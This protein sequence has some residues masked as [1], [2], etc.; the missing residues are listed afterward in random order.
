M[1]VMVLL[2]ALLFHSSSAWSASPRFLDLDDGTI[3]DTVSSLK[4]LKNSNCFG[5]KAWNAA[6]SSAGNLASGQ[7]GLND[8]SDAGDWHLPTVE[9][10]R[11]FTDAGYRYDTLNSAGFDNVQSNG[12]AFYW[13]GTTYTGGYPYAAWLVSMSFGDV[14]WDNMSSAYYVWPVRSGQDWSL[15]SL[16]FFASFRFASQNV[17]TT[18]GRQISIINSG[19]Y[20]QQ[21]TSIALVGTNAAEFTIIP[22]GTSPCPGLSP[23]LNAGES[24]SM[25]VA[26]G[27][28]SKGTKSANVSIS[29]NAQTLN[30][31]LTATGIS[32]ITGTAT[33]L[34]TGNPLAA[35]TITITGGSTT[36]SD[37]SGNFI[38][39]PS[40][41]D[42]I[43]TVTIT[44]SG[45]GSATINNV[46]ISDSAGANLTVGMAPAGT[47]V[48]TTP[49]PTLP[50]ATVGAAYSTRFRIS[51]GM[52]P[53]TFSIPAAMGSLPPG[54]M[55][56]PALGT[57]TGTPISAGSYT[58]SIN[59][60][61]SQGVQAEYYDYVVNVAAPLDIA[62]D[63]TLPRGTSNAPYST[64]INVTGGTPPYQFGVGTG[65][66]NGVTINPTSGLISG[67]PAGYSECNHYQYK[68]CTGYANGGGYYGCGNWH[69]N[70]YPYSCTGVLV[71][72]CVS[73]SSID[74]AGN[75][76][77]TATVTD[78]L[79]RTTSKNCSINVDNP[80]SL[81]TARLNDGIVGAAFTQTPEA[82]GGLAPYSWAVYSGA[83]PAG[84]TLDPATGTISGTPSAAGS[85]M[86]VISL[87][88][89]YNRVAFKEF[90]LNSL[91]PLQIVTTSM[92]NG[93]VGAPYS[94]QVRLD[95][96]NPPF[97][98][99]YS[100]SL[101]L[102]LNLAPATGIVSGTSTGGG[103]TN[104]SITVT[105]STFPSAQ[106]K[107]QN[108]S[109]RVWTQL[110][111]DSSAVLGNA[112]KNRGI[113]AVQL[114]ARGGVV[115]SGYSWSISGGAFPAGIAMTPAGIISGTP[116]AAGDYIATVRVTDQAASP[117]SAEKQFFIHVSDTL[118]VVTGA[119]PDG[120]VGT[121][122]TH[123][124]AA[125]GGLPSYSWA[126]KTGTLPAGL[127]LNPGGSI[128]GTPTSKITSSVTFEVTD[129]DAPAQKAQRSYTFDISDTLSIYDRSL[130]DGR[131]NHAY[132]ANI[133]PQL[134]SAP[135]SWALK[136]GTLPPG[137]SLSHNAGVATISGSATAA[138]SYSFELELSDN[139]TPVQRVVRSYSIRIVPELALSATPL[140]AAV[141]GVPYA[142]SIAAT[143]G[144]PPYSFGI[145]SGAL[146][147]GLTLNSSSG[148]ISGTI[149]L[150]AGE[151]SS[152][153]V[154]VTDDGNPQASVQQGFSIFAVD[155]LVIGT[156][157][158]QDALQKSSYG[159]V[160]LAGSGGISPYS[161][162]LADGTTLPQGITLSGSGSLAGN[163]VVCGSFPL[164][165]QAADQVGTAQRGYTLTILC[166][167]DYELAG[168][169]G[170]N[171]AGAMVV[172]SGAQSKSATADAGGAYLFRHLVN[173]SYSVTPVL[174]QRWFAEGS[175]AVTV[176]NLDVGGINFSS[177]IDSTAPAVTGFS[178]PAAVSSSTVPVTSLTAADN[179]GGSG[180]AGYLI[181]ETAGTPP[182]AAAG[183]SAAKPASY[184]FASVTSGARVLYAWTKDV[185][186]NISAALTATVIIDITAPTV[187]GF[188][189]P[190][191]SRS[192]TVPVST[193]SAS[194]AAGGSGLSGYLIRAVAGEPLA[195][196]SGWSAA[197]PE[198]FTFAA[199]SSGART[200]YAWAR[201]GAGNV[202]T[203]LSAP[204]LINPSAPSVTA[205]SLPAAV[206]TLQVP[207][208]ILTASADSDSI[209]GYLLTET[210]TLPQGSAAGWSAAKPAS[211]TMSASADGSRTIYAW[212]KDG[213]GN[214]SNWRSKTV[215]LDRA[216]P[217]VTAFSVPAQIS[218]GRTVAFTLL[219]A[220]DTAGGSGVAAYL[221]S[222]SA[223]VPATSAGGWQTA[224]PSGYTFSSDG[225]HALYLFVRD[226]AGNLSAAA[227]A[228][229]SNTWTLTVAVTGPGSGS[230]N[231]TPTG[232]A[233]ASGSSIG[234]S[235]DFLGGTTVNLSA[236]AGAYST[237]GGWSGVCTGAD[238]CSTDLTAV[239][240]V[241]ASFDAVPRA[242]IGS[243]GFSTLSAAYL[244]AGT[245]A[246]IL[247]LDT[248]LTE[249]VTMN[250]GK[251]ITLKGGFNAA[252]TGRTLL[253][254]V[255]KG[256]LKIPGGRLAADRLVIR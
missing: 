29:S 134:G 140:K 220:L 63:P 62:T 3:I 185:A 27:P 46:A 126:V 82:T 68:C 160:A 222:E 125:L 36:Q 122:Y 162:T 158:L 190:A 58:F 161:W 112:Q 196:D 200:L 5:Q 223:A 208:T 177:A 156:A 166:A 72:R 39:T 152:F 6:M 180:L 130:P 248:E 204:V 7:C 28:T 187:T 1:M 44:K 143:G 224:K 227:S 41:P 198:S 178:L 111:I 137:T 76:S 22:G 217:S 182:A 153:T 146:P 15:D 96:G 214:I 168:T 194:D 203:A 211:F 233:C 238:G 30:I 110:T 8:G 249:S 253:P 121:P 241:S 246:T 54:L 181:T 206:N 55:L 14:S 88:D 218:N 139:G 106:S 150:A 31:P 17:G 18:A 119:V 105:D 237:F 2:T 242:M 250:L 65:M 183:W 84:L 234:C 89:S 40:P 159:P 216:K 210:A 70:S 113:T 42:G 232:I 244:A 174:A 245:N 13:S 164:T 75:H 209:A 128:S 212:A 102:G 219:T 192:L 99:S 145:A 21:V 109:V 124:L 86:P 228:Q 172:L 101:P 141:R 66:P 148:S 73:Y 165:V 252:Y 226:G 98:Y 176:E 231:S 189:L 154:H 61:D 169:L 34:S 195:S 229:V 103:L 32:T 138:G 118:A 23:T 236:T 191:V 100:G 157:T 255:L 60:T 45:Y 9:E 94:E 235:N 155:P 35:A 163:P 171:G 74:I 79:G 12:Y 207:V 53:F 95:G 87:R 49:P 243:T 116:T 205:F 16:K 230:V 199:G 186:D 64:P 173:G 37:P 69:D 167:N 170:I 78:A 151:S 142:G 215:K 114:T 129:S 179:S 51:G 71:D 25:Q 239:R 254:T 184:T 135:Y 107:T 80:L 247:L 90:T 77:F 202:S 48:I 10:L 81:S 83:L 104:V 92:P 213:A 57:I 43:Y 19:A 47:L 225:A 197:R 50:A 11:I 144:L 149:N 147:A 201:D 251:T 67:T 123:T 133:R 256:T 24:C 20:P 127:N 120:A 136:S 4:W 26:F 175:R 108:L 97:I 115:G 131:V 240:T 56:D 52:G 93:F 33:D 59:V 193:L 188:S 221:L 117:A 85:R 132:S 91:K 38:F